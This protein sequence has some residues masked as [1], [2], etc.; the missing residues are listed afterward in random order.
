MAFKTA[1]TQSGLTVAHLAEVVGK[2]ESA[3]KKTESGH[4]VKGWVELLRYCEILGTTPNDLLG[5]G[6]LT[7]NHLNSALRPI[8]AYLNYN[9]DDADSIARILFASIVGAQSLKEDE[10]SEKV[11]SVS[12]EIAVAQFRNQKPKEAG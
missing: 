6:A 1:R 5:Y 11:Y 8:L 12:S 2:S 3:V 7:Q 9:P 10:P 4:R